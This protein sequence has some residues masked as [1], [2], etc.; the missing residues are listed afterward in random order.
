MAEDD[1]KMWVTVVT[2]ESMAREIC[3][4]VL[5]GLEHPEGYGLIRRNMPI[6]EAEKTFPRIDSYTEQGG[7]E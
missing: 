5:Y 6:E 1:G 7:C 3:E 2:P 4:A